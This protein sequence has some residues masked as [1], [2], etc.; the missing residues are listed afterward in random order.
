MIK[1]IFVCGQ[2]GAKGYSDEGDYPSGSGFQCLLK[3][4]RWHAVVLDTSRRAIGVVVQLT[5]QV[6]F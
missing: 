6:R 2:S 3:L 4:W 5:C 1:V